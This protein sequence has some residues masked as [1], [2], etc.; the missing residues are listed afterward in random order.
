M[1]LIFALNT[2]TTGVKPLYHGEFALDGQVVV[3]RSQDTRQG[4][5]SGFGITNVYLEPLYATSASPSPLCIA[6]NIYVID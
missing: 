6:I 4:I 2:S 1:L 3:K 5:E